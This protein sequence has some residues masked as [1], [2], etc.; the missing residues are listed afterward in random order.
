MLLAE[1][2]W[3]GGVGK[4]EGDEEAEWLAAPLVVAECVPLAVRVEMETVD[5]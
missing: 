3:E 2:V 1:D 5:E 4:L